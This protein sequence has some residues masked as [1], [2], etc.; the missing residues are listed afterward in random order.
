MDTAAQIFFIAAGFIVGALAALV[1]Q[2]L[3]TEKQ[4]R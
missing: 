4:N 3:M 2:L 1:L